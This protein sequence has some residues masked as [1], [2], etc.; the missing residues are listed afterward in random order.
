MSL[1]DLQTVLG[2]SVVVM[3]LVQLIKPYFEEDAI[4]LLAI[5]LGLVV[6]LLAAITLG[7]SSALDLGN[8]ILT[9][10]LGGASAIGL[11]QAQKPLGLLAPKA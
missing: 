10:F 5:G 7:Q 4:R 6:G 8:A 3:I 9:G 1:N 11:Y 2:V